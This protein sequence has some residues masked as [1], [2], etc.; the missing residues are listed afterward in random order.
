MAVIVTALVP[1]AS[2]IWETTAADR[3]PFTPFLLPVPETDASAVALIV[4]PLASFSAF[5]VTD[6]LLS[7]FLPFRR[8]RIP[9]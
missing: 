4:F 6:V 1:A 2:V 8:L 7:A 9:D 3:L 5:T